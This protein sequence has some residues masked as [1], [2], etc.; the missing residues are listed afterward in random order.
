MIKQIALLQLQQQYDM[1]TGK[2]LSHP[3]QKVDN[4]A[5]PFEDNGKPLNER[6][7]TVRDEIM[8]KWDY[9]NSIY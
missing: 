1:L 3:A 6:F 9:L 7:Q 2:D 5:N 8:A 4:K